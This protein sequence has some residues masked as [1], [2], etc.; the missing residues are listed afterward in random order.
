MS[1]Q[2]QP[3]VLTDAERASGERLF[4]HIE[5]RIAALRAENDNPALDAVRTA[6]LRGHIKGFKELLFLARPPRTEELPPGA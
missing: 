5:D 2:R 1:P 3:F 4:H 6:E